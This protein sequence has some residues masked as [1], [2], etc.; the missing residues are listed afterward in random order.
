MSQYPRKARIPRIND[1]EWARLVVAMRLTPRETDVLRGLM[2]GGCDKQIGAKAG[3]KVPTVRA[4]LRHM[5]TRLGVS[6]RVELVLHV[7]ALLRG[8]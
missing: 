3:I 8:D 1:G 4:H 7:M 6:D 2:R 5:F